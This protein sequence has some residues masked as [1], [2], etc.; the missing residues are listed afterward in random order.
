[1]PRGVR[2]PIDEQIALLD[3]EI[4]DRNEK[5]S[6]VVAQIKELESKK[7]KLLDKKQQDDLSK[8]ADLLAS[9][10]ISAEEA[11]AKLSGKTADFSF[12]SISFHIHHH[13]AYQNCCT[14]RTAV[15]ICTLFR[16]LPAPAR[17]KWPS[18]LLRQKA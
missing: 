2:K 7:Q 1:M 15:D 9:Q 4:A 16:A 10:G 3:Q 6:A 5:K 18:S 14:T 11:I 12:N 13:M 8:V 17:P